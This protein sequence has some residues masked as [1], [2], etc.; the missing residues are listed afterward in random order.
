V[1][2]CRGFACKQAALSS[3]ECLQASHGPEPVGA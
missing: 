2:Q 1:R 3:K